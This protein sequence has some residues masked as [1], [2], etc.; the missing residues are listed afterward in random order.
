MAKRR[1]NRSEATRVEPWP[2]TDAPSHDIE[3]RR[4]A[5]VGIDIPVTTLVGNMRASQ[6]RHPV[7][8]DQVIRGLHDIAD[9]VT[10]VLHPL[11]GRGMLPSTWARRVDDVS[12][13]A[14]LCSPEETNTWI[15]SSPMA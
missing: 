13:E 11:N 10:H 9:Q 1:R 4:G 2:I 12:L 14:R 8:R 15:P 6:H 7:D 5:I 3:K